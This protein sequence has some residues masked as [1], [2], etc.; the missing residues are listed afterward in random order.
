MRDSSDPLDGWKFEE[1]LTEAHS[2]EH[3]I[4]GQLHFH[5]REML[6]KFCQKIGTLQLHIRLFQ[7]DAETLPTKI[8]RLD[9]TQIYDR[10]EVGSP[11]L[12]RRHSSE[13]L[14]DYHSLPISLIEHTLA[15]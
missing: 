10:I 12:E 5:V 14:T 13:K 3:D 1:F 9:K 2:A 8:L 7:M 6:F 15:L 11:N 4:Y